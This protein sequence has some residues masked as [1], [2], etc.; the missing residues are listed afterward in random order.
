MFYKEVV[1]AWIEMRNNIYKTKPKTFNDIRQ[2]MIWGNKYINAKGK[3]IVYKTWIDSNII[4]I[5]DLISEYGGIC[6]HVVLS[7]LNCKTIWL[8]EILKLKQ[9]I[10]KTWLNILTTVAS[11]RTKVKQL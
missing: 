7:Y 9:A 6:E 8:I 11:L 5:N 2:Q 4:Y 1:D 10:S 3:C